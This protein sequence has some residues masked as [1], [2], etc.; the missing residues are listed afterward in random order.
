MLTALLLMATEPALADG[1]AP[2]AAQEE[3][4]SEDSPE[5]GRAMRPLTNPANPDLTEGKLENFFTL[6]IDPDAAAATLKPKTPSGTATETLPV[7]NITMAWLEVTIDGTKIG[8]VGPL[9]TAAIHGVRSG[10]YV[11]K[12]TSS[13]GYTSTSRVQ[14]TSE[15]SETIVPGNATA[16]KAFEDDYRKPGFDAAEPLRVDAVVGYTLPMPPAPEPEPDDAAE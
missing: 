7:V 5:H 8:T 3:G 16:A 12:M 4:S 6:Y 13:T 14:T 11:V 10:E 1:P 2:R 9:T 15:M